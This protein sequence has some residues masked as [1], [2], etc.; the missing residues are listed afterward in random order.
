MQS[1]A[2]KIK[3]TDAQMKRLSEAS[4]FV[5]GFPTSGFGQDPR[6]LEGGLPDSA[7]LNS[8]GASIFTRYVRLKSTDSLDMSS[9]TPGHECIIYPKRDLL[10]PSTKSMYGYCSLTS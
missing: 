7:L 9:S 3:L 6:A 8:V 1:Q 10:L 5:P 2:L 4:P